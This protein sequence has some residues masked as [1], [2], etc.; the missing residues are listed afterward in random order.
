ME[1]KTV[2]SYSAFINNQK[3]VL[4]INGDSAQL[5]IPN[6]SVD[7]IVTDPPYF[8]FIHYSELS[9]F[10]YAWLQLA[11][12]DSYHE[13]QP[14]NSSHSGEVQSQN[15]SHFSIQLGR[16]FSECFRV[17]KAQGLMVFMAYHQ[18]NHTWLY[19][20]RGSLVCFPFPPVR[21]MSTVHRQKSRI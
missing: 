10:F 15:P 14:E 6:E 5:P 3:A 12:K 13:F 17:L 2:D 7:A 19:T 11:L 4:V 21:L 20:S 1:V 9:D 16:V 18:I 8:D